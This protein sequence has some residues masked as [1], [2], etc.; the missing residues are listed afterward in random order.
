MAAGPQLLAPSCQP[1]RFLTIPAEIR[2]SVYELIFVD[3]W[4]EVQTKKLHHER[5]WSWRD[6]RQVGRR[7]RHHVLL[8]CRHCYREARSI[9]YACT[10]W[11]F[12]S[13]TV[14]PFLDAANVKPYLV[15]I[16]YVHLRDVHDLTQ[17]RHCLLPSLRYVVVGKRSVTPSKSRKSFGDM[18][19]E[20][21]FHIVKSHLFLEKE[22][23]TRICDYLYYDG[24]GQNFPRERSF[25][26]QFSV[27]ID[28]QPSN[29]SS[30]CTPTTWS[31]LVDLDSNA[32]EKDVVRRIRPSSVLP[33][34]FSCGT[35]DVTFWESSDLQC[36]WTG[37][38]AYAPREAS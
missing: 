15:C 23:K 18:S 31:F 10:L 12:A 29:A 6:I 8:S 21:T 34:Q 26:L 14:R 32:V 4:V 19:V 17:L 7:E 36:E 20:E 2:A 16:K 27:K 22:V 9:W 33:W 25:R 35:T 3:S 38:F 11:D 37:V 28:H 24:E 30:C 5:G 13:L 1:S